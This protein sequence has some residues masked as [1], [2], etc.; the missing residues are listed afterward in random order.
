MKLIESGAIADLNWHFSDL[1]DETSQSR[2][3][4]LPFDVFLARPELARG[5]QVGVDTDIDE[6]RPHL[7]KLALIVIEFSAYADGRGFSIAHRL[8][9]SLGYQGKIWGRGS[10]IADQYALAVQCGVDAVL[11]EEELLERQPID[12]WQ[13]AL[14]SAPTPYRFQVEMVNDQDNP[15]RT[16]SAQPPPDFLHCG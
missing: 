3:V 1:A 8:R 14:A 9:H 12:Q 13:E 16:N 11:V 6:L 4:I 15:G 5:V 7:D 2:N 10:L